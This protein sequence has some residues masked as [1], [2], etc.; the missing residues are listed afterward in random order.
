MCLKKQRYYFYTK[1]NDDSE[2]LTTCG[3]HSFPLFLQLTYI[4]KAGIALISCVIC[5][6]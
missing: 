3:F 6:G 4:C 1:T 2:F 5:F